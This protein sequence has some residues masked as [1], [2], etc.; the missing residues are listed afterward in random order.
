MGEIPYEA[1]P[2]ETELP[3]PMGTAAPV[4]TPDAEFEP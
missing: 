1:V 3:I 2:E 4:C